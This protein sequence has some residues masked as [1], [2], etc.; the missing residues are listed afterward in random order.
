MVRL[1]ILSTLGR[2][3]LISSFLPDGSYGPVLLRLAWHS[4][5]TYDKETKTG[6]RYEPFRDS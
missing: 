6:G 4:A 5:G 3:N 2:S 1:V